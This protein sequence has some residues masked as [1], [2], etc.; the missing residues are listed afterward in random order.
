MERESE[1]FEKERVYDPGSIA[2]SVLLGPVSGPVSYILY[3][4]SQDFG[5]D[6]PDT[7]KIL[8]V[9]AM[10]NDLLG[11][12]EEAEPIY[13]RALAIEEEAFGPGHPYVARTLCRLARHYN[14]RR[15]CPS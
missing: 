4:I 15:R 10:M 8:V 2:I 1:L 9:Q 3:G 7:A 12:L 6:D 11:R 13:K 14:Q 5:P